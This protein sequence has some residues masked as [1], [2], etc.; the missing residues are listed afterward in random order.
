MKFRSQTTVAKVPVHDSYGF[1]DSDNECA[2]DFQNSA[3][4]WK[5]YAPSLVAL[6][7]KASPATF[8]LI[9]EKVMQI[10]CNGACH[11]ETNDIVA[12]GFKKAPF[13]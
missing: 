3:I 10:V 13:R 4:Q 8:L 6:G 5:G 1:S 12:A 9:M 2:C 11:N 7:N